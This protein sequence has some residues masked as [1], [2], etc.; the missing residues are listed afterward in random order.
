MRHP[1]APSVLFW[2]V[3]ISVVL[4]SSCFASFGVLLASSST[5][6]LSLLSFCLRCVGQAVHMEFLPCG[7]RN[8]KQ[9]RRLPTQEGRYVLRE[10][11]GLIFARV[12]VRRR[13]QQ[14]LCRWFWRQFHQRLTLHPVFVFRGV[15]FILWPFIFFLTSTWIFVAFFG[16]VS[17]AKT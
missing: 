16:R 5:P 17:I 9:L 14:S 1:L 12:R 10:A 8:D 13:R 6:G 4:V 11:R 2:R 15:S 7:E 3:P